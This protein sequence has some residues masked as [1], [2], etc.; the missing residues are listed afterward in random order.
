MVFPPLADWLGRRTFT[1]I[2]MGLQT[3]VFIGLIAFKKYQVFY[4]L[5]FVLGLANIIRYLIAY[6]HLMEFVAY[7]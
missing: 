5:I 3:F 2:G 7:K 1:F 6:A 4:V